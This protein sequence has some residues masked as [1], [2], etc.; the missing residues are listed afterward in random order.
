MGKIYGWLNTHP[1]GLPAPQ[2]YADDWQAVDFLRNETYLG[3]T[4]ES[5][6]DV[7]RP[8]IF[9]MGDNLPAIVTLNSAVQNLPA[10][11]R[12]GEIVN[13][14]AMYGQMSSTFPRYNCFDVSG[15]QYFNQL[16]NAARD[17][18]CDG[19]NP[20]AQHLRGDGLIP[21][22][23]QRF[24]QLNGFSGVA[25][26]PRVVTDREIV[27]TG[28]PRQTVVFAQLGSCPGGGLRHDK[29]NKILLLLGGLVAVGIAFWS[30]RKQHAT[31]RAVDTQASP[32]S[33]R[34]ATSGRLPLPQIFKRQ[35]LRRPHQAQPTVL[36]MGV[37][38]EMRFWRIET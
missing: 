22:A 19:A 24:T 15:G 26:L 29:R 5:T 11:I 4:K 16:S 8:V 23:N 17:F 35:P 10:T 1:R 2:S 25:I 13:D 27:H 3:V 12:Y 30:L 31:A 36:T 9:D 14:N 21:A 38:G 37:L 34:Q 6:L 32:Q 7:R 33:P 20:S 18:L 28:A